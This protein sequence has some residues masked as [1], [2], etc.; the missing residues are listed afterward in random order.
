MTFPIIDAHQHIWDPERAAYDWLA[1][2]E[3]LNR[4]LRM[5]DAL[6]EQRAC[7]IAAT[8]L[9]QAA[10]N[11]E[12]TAFMRDV[13]TQH[14]SIAGIV[15]Y[16]PLED[17]D[18][19]GD[20]IESWTG[21]SLMVG[22]R[23]L[24]H[25]RA[26]PD[27]I[28]QPSVAESLDLIAE[29]GL[30]YDL[31]AVLP[32]HLEHVPTLSE[33]HPELRIVIDHLAKPPVGRDERDPWCSAIAEAA[34]NPLVS[35][36]VSGLYSSVGDPA[37]WTT[38]LIAPW[39]AHALSVFGAHRLMYGSDWPVSM[40]AGGYSQVWRG[41]QPLFDGLDPHQREGILGRT[42]A[43]VYRLDPARLP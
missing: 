8:I 5:E 7:G 31:V 13:A 34:E 26:D 33:R 9:V 12:D 1:G 2:N 40:S 19:T 36:K 23:T 10:D 22:V 25:D 6:P 39:F 4:P 35:A 20:V 38:D 11:S 18:A 17:P 43:E 30:S 29:A 37:A 16:A 15:G 28:L 42:A 21:D 14:P 27:W 32:R 3:L 24:I 41:L